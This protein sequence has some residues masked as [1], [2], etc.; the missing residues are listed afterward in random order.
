[1]T[2]RF[3]SRFFASTFRFWFDF[4]THEKKTDT[5]TCLILLDCSRICASLAFFKSQ[6]VL[7]VSVSSFFLYLTCKKFFQNVFQHLHQLILQNSES[8]EVM[9]HNS[10]CCEVF[11]WFLGV[12][13][14]NDV[15]QKI[16]KTLNN[17]HTTTQK[18]NKQ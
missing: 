15:I 17:T 1:M 13:D 12:A 3:D 18:A 2:V 11:W 5:H 14:T 6:T 16:E 7:F 4:C 8:L 10:N 9:T